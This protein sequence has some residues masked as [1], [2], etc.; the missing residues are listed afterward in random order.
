MKDSWLSYNDLKTENLGTNRHLEFQGTWV[1]TTLRP[2]RTRN[3]PIYTKFQHRVGETDPDQI[4]SDHRT[5][6]YRLQLCFIHLI[7]LSVSAP[8]GLKGQILQLMSSPL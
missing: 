8:Q 4:W 3:E 6:K 1:S 7:C 2:S 5:P